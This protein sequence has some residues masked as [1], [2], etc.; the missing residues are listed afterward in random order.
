MV[1]SRSA[2]LGPEQLINCSSR[3]SRIP[4]RERRELASRCASLRGGHRGDGTLLV[5]GTQ[6]DSTGAEFE[7]PG[8][9]AAGVLVES[10]WPAAA[11]LAL[12]LPGEI[13]V[14]ESRQ[15]TATAVPPPAPP[16]SGRG[17]VQRH[18]TDRPRGGSRR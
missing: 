14:P 5:E 13:P 4:S 8:S 6:W 10:A 9:I 11:W 12:G 1:Y 18:G 16:A 2:S 3:Q 15:S 17:G 7:S